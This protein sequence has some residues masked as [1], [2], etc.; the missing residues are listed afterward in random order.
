MTD[1]LN[2]SSEAD[3]GGQGQRRAR[4]Q[5]PRT[6]QVEFTLT[7]EEYAA[8]EKAAKRAGL[9]RGAYAASAV[10]AAAAYGS[11][12]GDQGPLRQVLVEL[13]R[14]AG[15]VRRIGANL[16]QAVAKLN[17]IGQPTETLPAYAAQRIRHADHIDAVADAV[18]EALTRRSR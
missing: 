5:V 10:M 14:A 11:P 16:N 7:V 13:M 12:V 6:H 17:A 8:I 1:I 3:S 15:L 9:A 4:Q 18:R 2:S